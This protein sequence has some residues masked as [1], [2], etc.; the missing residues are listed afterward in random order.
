M[1]TP[2]TKFTSEQLVGLT[3]KMN[4]PVFKALRLEG[5]R[6]KEKGTY[7]TDALKESTVEFRDTLIEQIPEHVKIMTEGEKMKAHLDMLI[8]KSMKAKRG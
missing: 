6:I 3:E 1:Q 2:T 5:E 4:D 8:E 7:E